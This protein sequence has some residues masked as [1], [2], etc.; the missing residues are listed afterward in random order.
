MYLV[1][2]DFPPPPRVR[3]QGFRAISPRNLPEDRLARSWRASPKDEIAKKKRTNV[4]AVIGIPL[5]KRFPTEVRLPHHHHWVKVVYQKIFP[6]KVSLTCVQGG[7]TVTVQ[8]VP[9][10]KAFSGFVWTKSQKLK[11]WLGHLYAR[12]VVANVCPADPLEELQNGRLRNSACRQGTR[13]KNKKAATKN[14]CKN[15]KDEQGK[16]HETESKKWTNNKHE[17]DTREDEGDVDAFSLRL[18]WKSCVREKMSILSWKWPLR[19]D[20]WILDICMQRPITKLWFSMWVDSECQNKIDYPP[21]VEFE[22]SSL[23]IQITC[24]IWFSWKIMR[25][26][27]LED[28]EPNQISKFILWVMFGRSYWLQNQ[29]GWPSEVWS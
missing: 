9:W 8:T 25:L 3:H 10:V 26:R 6:Q 11:G 14:N 28:V 23:K 29:T 27:Y 2:Q 15:N 21:N 24:L 20:L 17:T 7:W 4:S 22:V 13:R 19:I 12:W 1:L 16:S 18:C 5:E